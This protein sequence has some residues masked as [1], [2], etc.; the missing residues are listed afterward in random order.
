MRSL[1]PFAAIVFITGSCSDDKK[2]KENVD[3]G[4]CTY[5]DKF[6]PAKLVRLEASP[7][8]SLYNGW[9]E[10]DNPLGSG[11]KDTISYMRMTNRDITKEQ[12]QKDSIAV[13]NTYKYVVSTIKTGACNPDIR[14]IRLERY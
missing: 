14:T 3:G 1:L 10:I 8:S 2:E 6:Y 13:G 11:D 4:P 12:L 7:D 5:E 9:F